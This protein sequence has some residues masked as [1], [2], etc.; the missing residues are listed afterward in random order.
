MLL[1]AAVCFDYKSVQIINT[2][3]VCDCSYSVYAFSYNI[4]LGH[5]CITCII[6]MCIILLS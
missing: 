2:A 5:S 1:I 4:V 6:I 3:K